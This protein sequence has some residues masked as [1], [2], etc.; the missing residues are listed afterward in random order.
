M[1]QHLHKGFRIQAGVRPE[2]LPII[3]DCQPLQAANESSASTTEPDNGPSGRGKRQ[4][5]AEAEGKGAE[6]SDRDVML[7]DASYRSEELAAAD[8]EGKLCN[9]KA[10]RC[11]L[12]LG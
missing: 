11:A 9:G 1:S 8:I 4:D 10:L 2:D 3:L 12:T 7:S 6:L 5:I